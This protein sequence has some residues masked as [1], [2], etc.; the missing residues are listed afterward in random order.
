ME[1][2]KINSKIGYRRTRVR[3]GYGPHRI[4][5]MLQQTKVGISAD[6]ESD[7]IDEQIALAHY[8]ATEVKK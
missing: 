7:E 3:S 1:E 5:E 8:K 4:L 2:M 6:R